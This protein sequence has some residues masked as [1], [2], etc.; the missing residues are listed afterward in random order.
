MLYF[1]VRFIRSVVSDVIGLLH[2]QFMLNKS[3]SGLNYFLVFVYLNILL[4]C[5]GIIYAIFGSIN[6]NSLSFY[7]FR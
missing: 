4:M 5:I 3:L 7:I 6:W 1:I 2:L